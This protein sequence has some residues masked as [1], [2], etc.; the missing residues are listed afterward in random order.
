MN[1][2]VALEALLAEQ[3]ATADE[4][5]EQL[6]GELSVSQRQVLDMQSVRDDLQGDL[7]ELRQTSAAEAERLNS[8]VESSNVPRSSP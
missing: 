5:E 7:A 3:Q 2:R 4:L 1:A 8:E 6:R